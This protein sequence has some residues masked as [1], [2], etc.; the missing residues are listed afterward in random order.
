[1]KYSKFKTIKLSVL[2]NKSECLVDINTLIIKE[3]CLEDMP[4]FVNSEVIIDMDCVERNLSIEQGRAGTPNKSMDSAFVIS[5]NI[6]IE[7]LLVE[8]RFNYTKMKNL[9]KASLL[10]KVIGSI[11]ALNPMLN[12]H[13]RYFYIFNSD[14]K[15]Q[16]IRRF[17]NMNPS[18]PNDYIATDISELKALY[19]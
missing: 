7:I 4:M 5:D 1:M 11:S 13:P 2:L 17:R 14:L 16:A 8:Y 18:M 6:N 15:N 9:D 10:G 19:F 12:I 3:G